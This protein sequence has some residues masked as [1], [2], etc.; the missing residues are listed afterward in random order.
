VAHSI[1]GLQPANV[2]VVDNLGNVL[3]ETME[4]DS[5]AGVTQTQ[6]E[7]R[8]K[9]EQ[10]MVRKVE[11][12]LL[13]VLGPGQAV[14]RVA[15][16]INFNTLTKT[17]E[18][19]DPESQVQRSETATDETTDSLTASPVSAPVAPGIDG[20]TAGETNA[21][22]MAPQ[23]NN[24]T[25]KKVTNKQFEINKITSNLVQSAGAVQRLSAAVF[26][27]SKMK[28]TG[29]E[30]VAEPRTREELDK[31]K[32]LV[33]NALGMQEGAV[34][35]RKDDITV[36]E[37][38]FNDQSATEITETLHKEEKWSGWIQLFQTAIYPAL[39]VGILALLWRVFKR[40]PD[41][42]IPV[43]VPLERNGAEAHSLSSRLKEIR[44]PEGV[45]TV[46]LLNQ[47]IKENPQN[48]TQAIRGWM[49]RGQR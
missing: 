4:G 8:K 26:V 3:S 23:N 27:A 30:R 15:A 32:K 17:E 7:V 35:A 49:T 28:G 39:A 42:D 38:P 25:R 19:Y 6:L 20:N 46:D 24:R 47:L 9:F 36:E 18:T 44:T 40:T 48:M 12:M 33:Q 37:F 13:T 31:I 29:A 21:V 43:A 16:D 10:Y 41:L 45:V 1:E 34:G 14:V 2:S 11:G 22:A 5:V